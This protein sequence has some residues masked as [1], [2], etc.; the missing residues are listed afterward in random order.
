MVDFCDQDF[1]IKYCLEI[2]H[3]FLELVTFSESWG[4]MSWVKAVDTPI[5]VYF[6]IDQELMLQV[7]S[8]RVGLGATLMQDGK[9]I[10]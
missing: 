5:L 4:I 6:D 9:P 3:I 2:L 10:E 8:S 7:D 1:I